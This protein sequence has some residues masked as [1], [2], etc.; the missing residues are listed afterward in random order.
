MTN[1]MNRNVQDTE[2]C[3]E[4]FKSYFD[5]NNIDERNAVLDKMAS[6]ICGMSEDQ[7]IEIVAILHRSLGKF[8]EKAV[9]N[10]QIILNC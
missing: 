8:G 3:L 7:L 5:T 9:S 4:S 1:T 6:S 2:I 10:L